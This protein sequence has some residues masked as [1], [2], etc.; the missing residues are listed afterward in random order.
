LA[1]EILDLDPS[2]EDASIIFEH[3][4]IC[5]EVYLQASAAFAKTDDDKLLILAS[6]VSYRVFLVIRGAKSY[7]EAVG[8]LKSRYTRRIN[9]L[10]ARHRLIT[11]K[12]R[13]GES[14]GDFLLAL[15]TL[16][17][18]CPWRA[19][20]ARELGEELIRDVFVAGIQSNEIR[21]QLLARGELD[22]EK[23]VELAISLEEAAQYAAVYEAERAATAGW[24]SQEA[25]LSR[26]W[27]GPHAA[28]ATTAARSRG[29][30]CYFCGQSK[31]PRS[32][33]PAKD[34]FCSACGKKG[35]YAQVCQTN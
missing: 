21:T 24:I 17:R 3:W 26:E 28:P 4:L 5:L 12:Q 11:R 16:A 13:P 23:N 30:K 27:G 6:R 34:D 1:P 31:H 15:K 9:E 7:A 8:L 25:A 18:A 10:L 14:D 2:S 32:H 29:R 33:C 22:L 19:V 35:H 20:T